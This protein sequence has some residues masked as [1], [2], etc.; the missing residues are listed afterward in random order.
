MRGRRAPSV[1]RRTLLIAVVSAH[2][3][4]DGLL[5]LRV[6]VMEHQGDIQHQG[7][8]R[9]LGIRRYSVLSAAS[10]T[11]GSPRRRKECED[12]LRSVISLKSA[13]TSVDGIRSYEKYL[14]LPAAVHPRPK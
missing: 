6:G 8:I 14:C 10:A 7:Q 12:A 11:A 9:R 4:G 13:Q 3:H 2:C 5:R 1:L